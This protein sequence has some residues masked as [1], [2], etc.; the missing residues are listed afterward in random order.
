MVLK[1]RGFQPRRKYRKI[2]RGFYPYRKAPKQGGLHRYL[3]G[4]AF[5]AKTE[6]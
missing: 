5:V 3:L 2:D 6:T 4:E 1:G